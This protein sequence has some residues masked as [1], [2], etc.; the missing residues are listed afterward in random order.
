MKEKCSECGGTGARE[1]S[2]QKCPE[3]KGS[4]KPKSMNLM[5]LSEKDVNSFLKG[6][7]VCEK[8]GGSGEVEIKDPCPF[9]GGEGFLYRCDLC[10][11]SIDHLID[12][13]EICKSCNEVKVVHMLDDSCDMNELSVG[14]YYQA[15]VN[16]LASFGAFVN[17]NSN[18]RG[19]IH[20]SNIKAKLEPGERLVVEINEIRSDGKMD[21]L[22][23]S[24]GEH[25]IVEVEKEMPVRISSELKDYVGKLVRIEGE[26]LQIKQTGGPTIFVISDEGG[27]IPCAAFESAGERAYPDIDSDMV[28]SLTGEV[29]LRGEDLQLEVKS[30]KQLKGEREQTVRQR[31]DRILD[32]RAE[33][34]DI[35]FLAKSKILEDLRPAMKDVARIIKK[36]ILR[37]RPILLRH[38]ADADG[39]TAGVAIEKAILPLIREVNGQDGEYYFYKRSPSK[40]PFYEIMDVTK[41][42]SFALEDAE[43]HDQKLPLVVMVDNGSTEEDVPAMRQALIYGIDMV[44]VDHHNPDEVVD[45]YLLAHVNPAHVGG[46]FGQTAGML[47]T[48]VARMIN[49]DVTEQ[50]Q[51][52]PAIAAVGDRSESDEAYQYIDLV[53]SSYSL[54]DLQDIALALDFEAYWLKF[55][56]GRGIINDLL[57]FGDSTRH[58]QL[59]SL[60]CEQARAMMDEQL[61]ACM[62]NVKSQ[63]LPNGA[64]M[65]VL[66]VE[67]YAH[68]FTFPAPGKTSGEVHD[69]I[70]RKNEGK[71]IVTIGYGP[72]FAVI[73]SRGVKMNIPE[74]V[75]QLREEIV[76][77]G[78][79]GGGHL[80]VGSIKFVGGMRKKVL[81]K[82]VEKIGKYEVDTEI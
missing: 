12:G 36:A 41:D 6:S 10:G 48:E 7:S 61:E 78:V 28:V 15:E 55:N 49:P 23:R 25:K 19:L 71:P 67:N 79:N 46:D 75:R 82:L 42:I 44:V 4:G 56:S 51:H 60:L 80:V 76:G 43:R 26:V 72:D 16:N 31:I 9:C 40:A 2:I 21:L 47:S 18:L 22:P 1:S 24:V 20:S 17:L 62:P 37:S 73:R 53:S 57:N 14:K 33:P 69:K 54:E 27:I 66:D 77:G 81:S 64:I 74:I 58:K 8:C 35:E 3:C 32:Q 59:V 13:R 68:K 29:N 50:I 38:H 11:K 30:M 34:Y 5:E 52:L 70:C 63:Q 39:M 65:N 45:D